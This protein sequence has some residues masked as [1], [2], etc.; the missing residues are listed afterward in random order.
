MIEI[1]PEFLP[2]FLAGVA[3]NLQIAALSLLLGL[4]LGGPL[5]LLLAAGRWAALP[6]G[7]VV[8]ALRAAPSFVVM[9][10]LLNVLPKEVALG[11]LRIPLGGLT[12]VVLAQAVYAVAYVA[13][14][15]V[16]ALRA[17]R[18][19]DAA[20]AVLFLPGLARAFFVLVMASAT[21]AAVGTPEAVF[22]TLRAA[23]RL[24]SLGDRV[25]LF[26]LVMLFFTVLLR[27]GFAAVTL[28]RHRL[29]RRLAEDAALAT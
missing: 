22:V 14:N 7:G 25:Q 16:V 19:G 17:Q 29:E 24:P 8:A 1:L 28:L 11:G 13:D 20:T 9:F 21:A 5:A 12:A 18:A 23:E 10:F 2:R 15:G 6:A 27:S 3:V 4:L 26:L